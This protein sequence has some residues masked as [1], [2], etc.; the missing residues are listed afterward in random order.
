MTFGRK[1]PP[2]VVVPVVVS[3]VD[4]GGYGVGV[5]NEIPGKSH[6]PGVSKVANVPGG[7]ATD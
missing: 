6:F 2:S 3:C 1:Q 5:F 7:A 4:F